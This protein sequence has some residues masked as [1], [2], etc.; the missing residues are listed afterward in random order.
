[1]APALLPDASMPVALLV[2]LLSQGPKES[3]ESLRKNARFSAYF[4]RVDLEKLVQTVSDATCKTFVLGENVKGKISIIGP[5]NGHTSLDAEQFYAVFLSA[6]DANGFAVVPSGR[7]Q[8][9]VEKPRAK[10]ASI[11]LLI[12]E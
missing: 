11:P 6:L 10:G 12:D 7:Y 8:R 9:I 4:E 2:M 1:M 3:C 5:E